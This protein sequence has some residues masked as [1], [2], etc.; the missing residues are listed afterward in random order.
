MLGLSIH[1]TRVDYTPGS[2]DDPNLFF[3]IEHPDKS[4]ALLFSPISKT[5]TINGLVC[6]FDFHSLRAPND[7]EEPNQDGATIYVHQELDQN[8]GQ[9]KRSRMSPILTED[10]PM[11]EDLGLAEL[12]NN[13][14]AADETSKLR[15]ITG[16]LAEAALHKVI[17]LNR[18][19]RGIRL[20]R[21][22]SPTLLDL[23][24]TV[25]NAYYLEVSAPSTTLVIH[26]YKLSGNGH[27]YQDISSNI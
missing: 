2:E 13:D 4:S 9:I 26:T 10:L 6:F 25:F 24:P 21:P 12:M 15:R 27:L 5:S 3:E 1:C 14:P 8:E 22:L 11:V 20:G 18:R 16:D 23:A 19:F 17:G 7:E